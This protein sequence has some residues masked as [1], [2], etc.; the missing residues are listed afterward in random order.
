MICTNLLKTPK[1]CNTY[2]IECFSNEFI[3]RNNND[4]KNKNEQKKKKE[5]KKV[6]Q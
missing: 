3:K 4:K 6:Y 5:K 1:F 2:Y